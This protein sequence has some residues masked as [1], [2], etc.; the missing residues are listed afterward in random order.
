MQF[1]YLGLVLDFIY[2]FHSASLA[3]KGARIC[4]QTIFFSPFSQRLPNVFFSQNCWS[5]VASTLFKSLQ[6][7]NAVQL[8]LS[9][10]GFMPQADLTLCL[11][12]PFFRW[13]F[14]DSSWIKVAANSLSPPQPPSNLMPFLSLAILQR[15]HKKATSHRKLYDMSG[16]FHWEGRCHKWISF[17]CPPN[18]DSDTLHPDEG[19]REYSYFITEI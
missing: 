12:K 18:D 15:V 5:R 7:A 1:A 4:Y 19:V 10:A 11:L 8:S 14:R 13:I 17:C 3:V 6:Y 2:Y 16:N 9:L